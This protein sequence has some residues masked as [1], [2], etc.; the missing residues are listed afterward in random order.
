[1]ATVGMCHIESVAGSGTASVV[2]TRQEVGGIARYPSQ[3]VEQNRGHYGDLPGSDG[4][5]RNPSQEVEQ[6]RGRHCGLPGSDGATRN[7]LQEVEQ[8]RGCCC[9]LPVGPGLSV[10]VWLGCLAGKGG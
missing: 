1:M 4:A 3:G 6:C 8:G 5:T 9:G 2:A 7:L 10:E